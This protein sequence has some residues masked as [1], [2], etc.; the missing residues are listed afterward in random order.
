MTERA[1]H[2]PRTV[3]IGD[4]EID[5][6]NPADARD[7]VLEWFATP[8]PGARRVVTPNADYAVKARRDEAFRRALN[9]AD[10][11]VPDGMWIVYASRIAGRPLRST[12]TGRLLVPALATLCAEHDR[13]IGLFGAGPGVAEKAA[14]V[15]C[16]R[17]PTLRV[18]HAIS[19]PMGLTPGSADDLALVDRLR[20]DL[21]A[22]VFVGLGAPKQELWMEMHAEALRGSILVG[23][24]AGMDIIAGRFRAAPRW[25][26]NVGLEWAFR[27]AQEPRR[28][29]RRYL[30]D[31]PWIVYW[32]LRTRFQHRP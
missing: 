4:L 31:D 16:A 22:V 17:N 6:V 20:D 29:A 24:G 23:I 25:M 26:T 15:L 5:D 32:A 14:A 3:W 30:V 19:P 10:L 11:R 7:R 27:L 8:G 9:S 21:P 18:T 1:T 2:R 28:L 13:S 12:V